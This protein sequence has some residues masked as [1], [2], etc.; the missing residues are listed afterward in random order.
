M[1]NVH[2]YA[3]NAELQSTYGS[4]PRFPEPG[5]WG[6][7]ASYVFFREL[8]AGGNGQRAACAARRNCLAASKI[9]TMTGTMMP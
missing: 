6:S 9:A 3:S 8:P 7:N 5:T 4:L 1:F 2:D